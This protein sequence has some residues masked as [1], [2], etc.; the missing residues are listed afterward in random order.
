M[1]RKINEAAV[2]NRNMTLKDLGPGDP[3]SP[4]P[5]ERGGGRDAPPPAP[6][7]VERRVGAHLPA[8]FT[9]AR[10]RA[11]FFPGFSEKGEL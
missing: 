7:A 8:K 3:E 11:R 2:K 6:A 5:A 10:A 9:F 1:H 4:T